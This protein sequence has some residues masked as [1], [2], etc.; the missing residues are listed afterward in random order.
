M[1]NA[2]IKVPRVL[3]ACAIF[4]VLCIAAILGPP[5]WDE[6]SNLATLIDKHQRLENVP[7]P[8]IVFIGG[9][10]V[11]TGIDSSQIQLALGRSVVN[12]G[13]GVPLG[14]RYMFEEVKDNI[15]AGDLIVVFPE[16]DFFCVA[17]HS[18]TNA[19]LN[20]TDI[21]I[22]IAEVFPGSIKWIVCAYASYPGGVVDFLDHV[23]RLV[24]SKVE[25]YKKILPQVCDAYHNKSLDKLLRPTETVYSPRNRFNS[26]GDFTGHLKLA[27][28][29]FEWEVLSYPHYEF[30]KESLE[31]LDNFGKW[32]QLKEA[33]VVVIPPPLPASGYQ[34]W[35][36]RADDIFKHW[37]QLTTISVLAPPTR[38]VF[39]KEQFFDSPYHL[40][41]I[42][43]EARTQLIIRDLGRY[44]AATKCASTQMQS[45]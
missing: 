20:G 9:S 14:L 7:S 6:T 42:G 17:S 29:G 21:L 28:P 44:L 22:Q 24:R 45:Y 27:S 12:M 38:Y 43:R 16:Y 11:M 41:A 8:K 40:N 3:L 37:Q 25:F 33:R 13:L 35:G 32:A 15:T 26:F 30:K 10:N 2:Q 18:E 34:K 5:R 19:Q 36:S 31:V 39:P 1:V 23:R 4:F